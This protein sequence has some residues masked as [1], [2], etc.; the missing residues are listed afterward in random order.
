ML[1]TRQK[2]STACRYQADGVAVR[3]NKPIDNYLRAFSNGASSHWDSYIALAEFADASRFHL[4]ISMAH[5]EANLS[6]V[7]STP[8]IFPVQ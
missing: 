6:Y 8:A 2:L 1:G 4:P 7:P 3:L 5:F